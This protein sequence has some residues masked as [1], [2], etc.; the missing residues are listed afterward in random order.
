M[1]QPAPYHSYT[2]RDYLDVEDGSNVKHEFFNGE[3]Y[4]MAGG[5][6]EHAA[7]AMAIGASLLAQVKDSCRV[8]GADLR[9]RVLATGLATYPDVSVICGELQRDPENRFTATNPKILVEVLSD[10]TAAYD[11]GEKL[12][13]YKVIESVQAVLLF[14]QT[15]RRVE[16][17]ERTDRGWRTEVFTNDQKV[18]V[19]SIG[20]ELPLASIYAAAGL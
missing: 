10:S 6:P 3:I 2:Y 12:E 17:H 14:S 1:S 20:A 16:L 4:A 8:Y 13:Q 11:R 7:L 5:T 9:I 15:S 19:P 18:P